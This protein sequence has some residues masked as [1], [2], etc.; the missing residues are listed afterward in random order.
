MQVLALVG[1]IASG[2]STVAE[3]FVRLGIPK[4]DA[5]ELAHSAL[6]IPEIK[7][8][9][10]QRWGKGVFEDD[11]NLDRKRIAS[12]VFEMSD[13][14]RQEL[15]FLQELTHP[16]VKNRVAALIQ[17]WKDKNVLFVLLDAPLLLE[18]GWENGVDKILFVDVPRHLRLSRALSRGWT[19]QE[20]DV[21][22]N[23]QL[24]VEQKRSRADFV[25]DNSG[26]PEE[27]FEQIKRFI[28]EQPD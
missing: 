26:T 25:I 18:S 13:E 23:L 11:E 10:C 21:R 28:G 8:K 19:E 16:V 7:D 14:G 27:T 24:P 3:L 1:G 20:F 4:I 9:I 12:I 5:D 6:S 17:Q 15:L 22:E 2:K